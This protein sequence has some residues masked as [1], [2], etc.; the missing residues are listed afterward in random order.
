MGFL[1]K[2]VT[3][4]DTLHDSGLIH[5]DI[6]LNNMIVDETFTIFKFIDYGIC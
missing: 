1:K 5:L 6:K 3:A 2:T 4:L